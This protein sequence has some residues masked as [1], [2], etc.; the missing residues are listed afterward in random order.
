M[1]TLISILKVIGI[2]YLL[3]A[4][5]LYVFQGKIIFFTQPVSNPYAANFKKY[6]FIVHHEDTDL[7]GW[8]VRNEISKENPLI[9]Y[10]GGNAEEVSGNLL[11]IDRFCTRSFLFINYRGYGKSEGRPTQDHLFEDALYI[12]D[13]MVREEQVNPESIVLMGRSLGSGVAVHV[14]SRRQ[15]QGVILVTPFDSLEKVAKE[16]YSFMPVGLLLRHR[17]NSAA[18]APDIKTPA[19]VLMGTEDRI[20]PNSRTM[21]LVHAWG[22]T[23]ETVSIESSD[24]NSIHEYQEYWESINRFIDSLRQKIGSGTHLKI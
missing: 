18:L 10:Y 5:L 22:G 3:L 13:Y 21:E 20:I 15:V 6:E 17:F 8:F 19:L 1:A 24:H 7:H 9:I 2:G 4:G 11:D 23:V 16:H 12:F 14:A